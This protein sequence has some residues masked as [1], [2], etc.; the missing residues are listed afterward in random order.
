MAI[1]ISGPRRCRPRPQAIAIAAVCNFLSS[2]R[3]RP[4]IRRSKR[5]LHVGFT[6]QDAKFHFPRD[7]RALR[8]LKS[9]SRHVAPGQRGLTA[10]SLDKRYAMSQN[11]D[12]LLHLDLFTSY[13]E[14]SDKLLHLGQLDDMIVLIPMRMRPANWSCFL[15]DD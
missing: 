7:E 8:A 2:A 5:G 11:V 10:T 14:I 1:T 3:G 15:S 12:N 4:G 13:P 9:E 6:A